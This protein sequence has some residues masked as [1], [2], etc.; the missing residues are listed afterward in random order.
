MYI[1]IIYLICILLHYKVLIV[2]GLYVNCMS[3]IST[4]FIMS[5]LIYIDNYIATDLDL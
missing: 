4:V 5:L 3:R 1:Y 2:L